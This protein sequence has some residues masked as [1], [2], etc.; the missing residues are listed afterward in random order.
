M[1]THNVVNT[2]LNGQTGTGNF[3]GSASP[4]IVTPTLTVSGSNIPVTLT[5][6]TGAQYTTLFS[7]IDTA[8]SK[9]VTFP[10]VTATVIM[11]DSVQDQ[12]IT[13]TIATATPAGFA[14]IAP[15]M[16]NLTTMTSG[17]LYGSINALV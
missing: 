8:S 7:F 6:G 5:S 9:T 11:S 12:N 15:L 14:S 1:T 13:C 16:T 3:V 2:S 4:T 10:D 17:E